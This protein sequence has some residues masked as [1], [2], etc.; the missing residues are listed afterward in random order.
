M[1]HEKFKM[2]LAKTAIATGGEVTDMILSVYWDEFSSW[3]DD[4]FIAALQRCR[5]ELNRFPTVAQIK[6]RFVSCRHSNAAQVIESSVPRISNP[7]VDQDSLTKTAEALTDNEIRELMEA[8]GYN[9]AAMAVIIT[10]QVKAKLKI[11][12][13]KDLV[14]PGWDDGSETAARCHKC[15]DRGAIEVYSPKSYLGVKADMYQPDDLRIKT[16]MVSCECQ[17]GEFHRRPVDPH[18][19]MNRALPMLEFN[20]N[21][22][23]P[24]SAIGLEDQRAELYLFLKNDYKPAKFFSE[25]ADW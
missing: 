22:M 18:K 1:D 2:N 13:L 4:Q 17:A 9:A 11:D 3:T 24:V 6:E 7:E 12:L 20:E 15:Q 21:T 8:R 16:V 19:D 23:L 25:F 5:N 10:G 14:R